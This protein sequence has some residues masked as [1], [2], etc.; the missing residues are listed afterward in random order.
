MFVGGGVQVLGHVT[1]ML[2]GIH[3]SIRSSVLDLMFLGYSADTTCPPLN[4][5]LNLAAFV[6]CLLLGL[7]SR[8]DSLEPLSL[9]QTLNDVFSQ[10]SPEVC[11]SFLSVLTS[12]AQGES[13]RRRLRTNYHAHALLALGAQVSTSA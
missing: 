9:L 7:T 2:P 11:D 10:I 1:L 12:L 5:S 13:P 8:F 6:W 4:K 3:L